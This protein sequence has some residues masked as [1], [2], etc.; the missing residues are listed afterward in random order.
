MNTT[1]KTPYLLLFALVV[2]LASGCGGSLIPDK[3]LEPT[4]N[5]AL[6]KMQL[7]RNLL[8]RYNN[9][10]DWSGKIGRVELVIPRA[11]EHSVNG[12]NVRVEFNQIV[13]DQ[14]GKRVPDLEKEYFFITFGTGKPRLVRTAPSMTIGL[15]AGSTYSEDLPIQSGPV[16]SPRPAYEMPGASTGAPVRTP[17]PAHQ[18]QQ[19]PAS[20]QPMK[21]T[22]TSVPVVPAAPSAIMPRQVTSAPSP[23]EDTELI[24]SMR[25]PDSI[26]TSTPRAEVLNLPDREA[27]PHLQPE[28][29]DFGF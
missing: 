29:D 21:D 13:Y 10:P 27:S 17:Q 7:E 20:P 2:A 19:R 24:R 22:G 6:Y 12:E 11:P 4:G 15:D 23:E 8:A 28:I 3:K 14:W 18:P 9:L 25:A 5:I 1:P 16:V 26:A